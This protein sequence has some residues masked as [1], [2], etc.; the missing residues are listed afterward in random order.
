M[1]N[2]NDSAPALRCEELVSLLKN[3]DR[4]KELHEE[5][6]QLR[7]ENIALR[8][9]LKDMYSG[10]KYIRQVHGEL[11]GVGW[12]RVQEKAEAALANTPDLTRE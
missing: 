1:K 9:A 6:E 2:K 7:I 12:N 4:H 3:M 10:W 8:E 5:N 11:Y